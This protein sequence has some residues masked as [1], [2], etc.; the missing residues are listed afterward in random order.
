MIKSKEDYISFREQAQK[1]WTEL[2]EGKKPV[3]TVGTAT[4][5]RSAGSL[6]VLEAL[7]ESITREDVPCTVMEVGCIGLCFLEPLVSIFKPP[8]PGILYGGISPDKTPRLVKEHLAEGKPVSEWAIGTLAEK[9]FNGINP[10]SDYSVLKPQLRRV[11]KKCGSIEPTNIKHYAAHQGYSGLIRALDMEPYHIIEELKQ[12]GLRGRGGAGFPTGVKWEFAYKAEGKP[13][14]IVCNADEG[15][16]G[17]FMNRSVLE[18]DSHAVLEGMLVAGYAVGA[19]Q[20]Y[21]YCR[22]EYPLALE[23]L[24]EAISQAE[25]MGLLGE[26]ILGSGFSFR[27]NIKEG[28]GAFVCGEETSLIASI[29]GKR[30]MPTTR[31]PY[32]ATSGLW[33]KPTII[34]NVGTLA[35]VS[36]IL[37]N[38]AEW[39]SQY[40]TQKSKG[41]KTFS[42]AGKVN[43]TGLIEVP[44]GTT[45]REII[46]EIGGGINQNK[47]FKAVQT[48]GPSGGCIPEELLDLP[49]DYDSLKQAGSIMGSGGLVVMDEDNCMVD[50][51]RYFLDF[52]QKESC[53]ECVPC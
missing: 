4:C 37:Q 33:G 45:L 26:N 14:Y 8:I 28:A 31:P 21:I 23:R 51:A 9:S 35:S 50:V 43:N 32:P 44:L 46:F 16:P 36:L 12:S 19:D 2:F 20:G 40:G 42:L 39:F 7:E 27:I 25:E 1:E 10:L 53:G 15:D 29:E 18:S 22:A 30:G 17:A 47:R 48:G 49:V 3:V 34:N 13:K 52:T 11:L 38:N 24:R 41:T 6:E 5:G